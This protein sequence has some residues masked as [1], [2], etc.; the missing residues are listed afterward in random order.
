L[1]VRL[2]VAHARHRLEGCEAK[3]G[4]LI[5]LHLSHAREAFA[6]LG[7]HLAQL[8][9]LKILDRGYAIVEHEGKLVKSPEDAPV[10]SDVQVRLARGELGARVTRAALADS[11]DGGDR[12]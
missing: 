4:Q 1:D 11:D 5:K 2:R 8:S 12:S 9:P 3:L 10:G 7:A 6:P